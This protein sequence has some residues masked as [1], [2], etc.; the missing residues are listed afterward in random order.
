MMI[1]I[2]EAKDISIE[3]WKYKLNVDNNLSYY[4]EKYPDLID[5]YKCGFCYRHGFSNQLT[6]KRERHEKCN[7]CE[8]AYSDALPCLSKESL[9]NQLTDYEDDNEEYSPDLVNKLIEIISQIP[10]DE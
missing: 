5:Y 2:K 7:S 10:E 3:N 8:L 1:S 6:S 9:Y 4:L